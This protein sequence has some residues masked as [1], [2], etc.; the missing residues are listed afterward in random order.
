M[1]AALPA[2][3]KQPSRWHIK[4][5][6]AAGPPTLVM[7]SEKPFQLPRLVSWPALL[8]I[9]EAL[10]NRQPRY[11]YC[12]WRASTQ[13]PAR[14]SHLSPWWGTWRC[15]SS[16]SACSRCTSFCTSVCCRSTSSTFCRTAVQQA[17]CTQAAHTGCSDCFG[18]L[19][20]LQ[21]DKSV[22]QAVLLT[23]LPLALQGVSQQMDVCSSRGPHQQQRRV[24]NRAAGC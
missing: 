23:Y 22:H 13:V 5:A 7:S 21:C 2:T 20:H 16:C 8:S 12:G 14:P 10:P 19:K 15:S 9:W 17:R 6:A 3:R 11:V 1:V 18:V 24:G 4:G